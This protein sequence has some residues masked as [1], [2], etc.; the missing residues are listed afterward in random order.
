MSTLFNSSRGFVFMEMLFVFFALAW[1]IAVY[2]RRLMARGRP[3]IDVLGPVAPP[4]PAANVVP[5]PTYGL[6]PATSVILGSSG[7]IGNL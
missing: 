6:P 4:G 1:I 2:V 7:N 3:Y 5:A